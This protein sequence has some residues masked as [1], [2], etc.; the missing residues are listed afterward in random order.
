MDLLLDD[1]VHWPPNATLEALKLGSRIYN[2]RLGVFYK[3]T[4]ISTFQ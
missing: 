4:A 2:S 3:L 1:L